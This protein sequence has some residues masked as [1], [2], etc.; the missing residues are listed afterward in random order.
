MKCSH[1]KAHSPASLPFSRALL[2]RCKQVY[3][4]VT[5]FTPRELAN[6]MWALAVLDRHPGWVTDCVLG[7]A[8]SDGFTSYSANSLHLVLWSLGKLDYRPSR[9]WTLEFLKA[10]QV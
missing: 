4:N 10:S 9:E 6:L 1:I 5:D 7:H 8:A 3:K 2:R